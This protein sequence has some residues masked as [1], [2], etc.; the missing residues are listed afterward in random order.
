MLSR[1]ISFSPHKKR[2]SFRPD[3]IVDSVADINF[4]Y[5]AAHGIRAALIDLD[6]TVVA[7]GTYAVSNAISKHLAAQPMNIFI[8]TN[9]PKSRS[10]KDLKENLHAQGVIHPK[11]IV[12]KPFPSYYAQA[13]AEHGLKPNECMMIGDRFVQD[14]F[15][16]NAAGLLT[17]AVKKLDTPTNIIDSIISSVERRYVNR[18]VQR[19]FEI[20]Q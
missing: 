4:E 12:G 17:V 20:K 5:L 9:R 15:G 19:Y 1:L 13:A 14:I 10:L 16:A 3:Y 18:L 11:G 6:G 7:R 8:A 2:Y